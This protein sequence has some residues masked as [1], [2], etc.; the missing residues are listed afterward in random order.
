MERGERAEEGREGGGRGE[1]AEKGGESGARGGEGRREEEE[2]REGKERE[3]GGRA[4]CCYK[5]VPQSFVFGL[6]DLFVL[7]ISCRDFG[8]L[9]IFGLYLWIC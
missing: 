5:R 3:N 9:L 1:S 4:E 2:E 6:L 8:L 7:K